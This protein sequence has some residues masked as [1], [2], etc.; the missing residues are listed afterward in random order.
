MFCKSILLTQY[1]PKTSLSRARK[2]NKNSA[3]IQKL[4]FAPPKKTFKI[5]ELP[6]DTLENTFDES[7]NLIYLEEND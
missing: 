7:V 3:T 2:L 4:L 6:V 1:F 5:P